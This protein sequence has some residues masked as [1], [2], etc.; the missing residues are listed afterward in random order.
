MSRPTVELCVGTIERPARYR[1]SGWSIITHRTG[2]EGIGRASTTNRWP[3]RFGARC[4][5][6]CTSCLR[7]SANTSSVVVKVTVQHVDDA[8]V[9]PATRS[10][11]RPYR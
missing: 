3:V 9:R 2:T 7:V 11:Q 10:A 5:S 6:L 1:W 4:R 8:S